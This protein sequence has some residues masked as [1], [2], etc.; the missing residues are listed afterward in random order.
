MCCASSL[1]LLFVS[2]D[3]SSESFNSIDQFS[4]FEVDK[5]LDFIRSV[6]YHRLFVLDSFSLALISKK[7]SDSICFLFTWPVAEKRKRNCVDTRRIF[8]W[9]HST[10]VQIV[11]SRLF[12]LAL[13]LFFCLALSSVWN[14]FSTADM[15]ISPLVVCIIRISG[16]TTLISLLTLV[17]IVSSTAFK[18][19]HLNYDFGVLEQ[20]YR[21]SALVSSRERTFDDWSLA[22]SIE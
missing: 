16:R 9:C 4:R 5:H 10:Y 22:D 6:L 7:S 20:D 11:E 2:P 13:D 8:E 17:A 15:I 3:S 21:R 19:L 12:P 14:T 18:S 1:I